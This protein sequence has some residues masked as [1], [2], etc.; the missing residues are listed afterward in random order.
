MARKAKSEILKYYRNDYTNIA[1]I[2]QLWYESY[3][4]REPRIER[5]GPPTHWSYG[6]LVEAVVSNHEAGRSGLIEFERLPDQIDIDNL[7][8]RA[9]ICLDKTVQTRREHLYD[10]AIN[11]Q[12][13]SLMVRKELAVGA[14]HNPSQNTSG[15]ET[16][17]FIG[18]TAGTIHA[19][20]IPVPFSPAD[21]ANALHRNVQGKLFILAEPFSDAEAV[22]RMLVSTR[23]TRWLDPED[24][25]EKINHWHRLISE[26]VELL[27]ARGLRP[28]S[29]EELYRLNSRFQEP[30][31][32]SV[33]K[34]YKLGYYVSR[35][36]K[37]AAGFTL[38][39]VH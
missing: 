26:R 1:S 34:N 23:E 11:R 20:D 13:R 39:R 35:V 12:R 28:T 5:E 16:Y 14:G 27:K 18:L 4:A 24:I 38:N 21:L 6:Q 17:A 37:D 15:V 31:S 9:L 33:A 19:H 32:K 7:G 8:R 25:Q 2:S 22:M 10:I 30:L 3:M 36:R 29:D